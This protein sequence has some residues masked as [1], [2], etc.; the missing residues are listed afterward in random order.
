MNTLGCGT[1]FNKNLSKESKIK[2]K[3]CPFLLTEHPFF[4]KKILYF[5]NA[6][7]PTWNIAYIKKFIKVYVIRGKYMLKILPNPCTIKLPIKCQ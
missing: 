4:Y 6:F 2:G 3:G 1:S 5:N 7:R